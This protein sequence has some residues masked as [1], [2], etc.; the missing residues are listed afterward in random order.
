MAFKVIWSESAT[1]D[2]RQIVQFIARDNR[3]AA[4]K[5]AKRILQ[6]VETAS[7][8]PWANRIVPEKGDPSIREALLKPYRIIYTV[9]ERQ[10]AVQVLRIWHAA[11]GIPEI[12]S[13]RT[14]QSASGD[15]P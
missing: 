8:L 11:R 6:H 2:L 1:N 12:E 10:N 4:V 13:G 14:G 3:A 5:L 15:L 7:E 9:Q